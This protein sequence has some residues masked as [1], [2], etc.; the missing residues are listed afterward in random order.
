MLIP[1]PSFKCERTILE[2]LDKF[3]LKIL[4]FKPL[5]AKVSNRSKELMHTN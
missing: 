3:E 5:V 4:C 1:L 2:K